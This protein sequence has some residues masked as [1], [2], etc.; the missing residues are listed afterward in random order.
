VLD[1]RFERLFSTRTGFATLDRLLQRLR[2]NKDELLLAL[3]RPNIPLH[4]NDGVDG[5]IPRHRSV[6]YG[7]RSTNTPLERSRPI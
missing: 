5:P 3:E 7:G 6:P 2:A 4:T 1:K